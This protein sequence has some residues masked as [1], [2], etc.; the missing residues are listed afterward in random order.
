VI[1]LKLALED[2]KVIEYG[3]LICAPYCG[4]MLADLGA[5]VIKIEKPGVGDIARRRAPFLD[6]IP[7][8]E[9]SGMFLD[10]NTNKRGVTLDI[11]K[12]TGR[13]IFKKLISD[14]DILIED[15]K[16]GTLDSLG[17]GYDALKSIN[18]RLVMT[19]I[20]PF[21]QTG[22]YKDY[23][24]SDLIAW[25]MG[26]AG[27]V[28]PRWAGTTEQE[29][30]R[31]MQM[32]SFIT[33][34]TAAV[35]TMCALR[36]QRCT[37]IGQQ[38]DVS[39]LE[40]II[41][42]I[43]EHTPVWPYEHGNPTR[44]SR[45]YFAPFHFLKCKDGWVHLTG[46]DYHWQRFVNIMDNPEWADEELFGDRF[47]RG[48]YWES[49]EP[50][51]T[52]WTMKHTKADLFKLAKEKKIPLAPANSVAEVVENRQL[53]ERGFFIAM[54]H[55]EA[56]KLTCPGAPYKFS[57]TPWTIRKPAPLLGQHN[58]DIYCNQLGYTKRELTKM[59]EAGII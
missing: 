29:P 6:D 2:V 53:K 4:K 55:P 43:A 30:L 13:E 52:E 49:L 56:G 57:K 38:V 54:E 31:V 23:K 21:G 33:G 46:D 28:T 1:G 26:G 41:A 59:Y 17:L 40:A 51:I 47:S 19:S 10:L 58:E 24:G 8:P 44:V 32:A 22:P 16:P 35:A 9:R 7:G 34:I 48:D 36:V 39:Q 27:Y 37:G 42:L 15:T 12:A 14:A 18:P 5:D 3:N 20:T 50:L 11:E 45:A 25:H